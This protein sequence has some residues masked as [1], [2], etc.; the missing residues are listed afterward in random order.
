MNRY[1]LL[2]GI[3]LV[4]LTSPGTAEEEPFLTVDQ[5]VDHPAPWFESV[6]PKAMRDATTLRMAVVLIEFPDRK[7]DPRTTPD[8]VREMLFSRGEHVQGADGKAAHGSLADYYAVQSYGRLAVEGHVFDWM[9][10]ETPV[11]AL[12][13][14]PMVNTRGK[15]REV[16]LATLRKREGEDVLAGYH[17]IC[18]VGAGDPG[19]RGRGLWPHRGKIED[20]P[21]I[22]LSEVYPADQLLQ[23]GVPAHEFGH[24]FG[25]KDMYGI[26]NPFRGPGP[27]SLMAR[28]T[29][30]GE[31]SERTRPFSM[32]AWCRT[33]IG[34]LKPVTVDPRVARKVVL[35]PTLSGP[36]Q[37][38]RVLVKEDGSEYFL[39]EVRKREGWETDLPDEGL[40][41]WHVGERRN[42]EGFPVREY[43][44]ILEQPHPLD[45]NGA[46]TR[47]AAFSCWPKPGQRHF[48]P[49]SSPSSRSKSDDALPVF[50]RNITRREDGSV[51]LEIGPGP[52]PGLIPAT[53]IETRTRR[54]V[55]IL[56][57]EE[58]DTPPDGASPRDIRREIDKMLLSQGAYIGKRRSLHRE[59]VA[60]SLRDYVEEATCLRESL[61]GPGV[62]RSDGPWTIVP[63]GSL[64]DPAQAIRQALP[65]KEEPELVIA[66]AALPVRDERYERGTLTDGTPYL[67][68]RCGDGHF[69]HVG[70]MA[71][72]WMEVTR[73]PAR[74]GLDDD[75]LLGTGWR[76][77][78]DTGPR[79][80][81]HPCLHCKLRA[82]WLHLTTSDRLRP[83]EIYGEAAW[84]A[85]G[86]SMMV[87]R[88][89][90][91]FEADREADFDTPQIVDM[92]RDTAY[93]TLA[94]VRRSLL[95]VGH[96]TSTVGR[97]LHNRPIYL[98]R[99]A[100]PGSVHPDE[101]P[102]ILITAA[103][104]GNEASTVPAVMTFVEQVRPRS[105]RTI[106]VMP[107]V[108]A[109]AYEDFVSKPYTVWRPRANMRPVDDDKDG[110]L[111]EDGYEDLNGDGQIGFMRRL[112][113][114]KWKMLGREGIDNDED[115][116]FSED[117]PGGVDLNR[118][119]PQG[120]RPGRGMFGLSRGVAPLSEPESKA[121]ADVLRSHP[122]IGLVVDVHN[123]A[124]CLF[125]RLGNPADRKTDIASLP[126]YACYRP[127]MD[128]AED[129]F[130]YPTRRCGNAGLLA[131]WAYE[132][133]GI[134]GT[135][136]E[137]GNGAGK[138]A[139]AAGDAEVRN[140]W[141]R[142]HFDVDGWNDWKP[143]DH[144]QLGA[145]EIG[146]DWKTFVKRSP[147]AGHALGVVCARTRHFLDQCVD[148]LPR[149]RLDVETGTPP[150]LVITNEGALPTAS[151]R[152]HALE[153]SRARIV[154]SVE[155]GAAIAKLPEDAV[156]LQR[157]AFEVRVALPAL[158][159]GGAHRLT[160]DASREIVAR[161]LPGGPIG[162]ALLRWRPDPS[163]GGDVKIVQMDA[164][165]SHY[166]LHVPA[167]Y[168]KGAKV[169]LLVDLHGA[170]PV[171]RGPARISVRPWKSLCAE[172]GFIH[173]LP[174][175]RARAWGHTDG[176]EAFVN[177]CI[178]HVIESYDIDEK[179]IWLTGFSAGADYALHF[180]TQ[181]PKRFA[182][183][184][185]MMPGQFLY[186]RAGRGLSR[187]GLENLKEIPL[188]YVTGSRDVRRG[189]VRKIVF[190]LREIGLQSH[191]REVPDVGHEFPGQAEYARIYAFLSGTDESGDAIPEFELAKKAV[192]GGHVVIAPAKKAKGTV[193]V[194]PSKDPPETRPELRGV[195]AGCR[196]RDEE[197]LHGVAAVEREGLRRRVAE[198]VREGGQGA[199]AGDPV[200]ARRRGEPRRA[201]RRR[202]R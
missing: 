93:P 161:V 84:S 4:G 160:L 72:W 188:L 159:A 91:G 198:R 80:P 48:T 39:L 128:I 181:D 122:N 20:V 24:L 118:N 67:L 153:P 113:D 139:P 163:A 66:F 187:E 174:Q 55:P 114:G 57:L 115:G 6:T 35:R 60:G 145:I 135:I 17:A 97:T 61:S 104:H 64:A 34:W 120:W 44:T 137:I 75:C 40:L 37:A 129:V 86:A 148:A 3:L 142:R 23:V 168:K 95:E 156:V 164:H 94:D 201:P 27:W 90:V 36:R 7:H 29:H 133:N 144:P 85:D 52:T 170:A 172:H 19:R 126:D 10:I 151:H 158:P 154:L 149:L 152:L 110:K 191:I 45:V 74:H 109:D 63:A 185:P 54:L 162:G 147:P 13:Q 106:Y 5:L 78:G 116:K 102:A 11:A 123:D 21:Y 16:A 141:S 77:A 138:R 105:D 8:G 175:S 176:D 173:V 2:A 68:V 12:L 53:K 28:G 47:Y 140:A 143:F 92:T 46:T 193:V 165:S 169:P 1:A 127:V 62:K 195:R 130:G 32:C 178:E 15:Y 182:A 119:F 166:V 155:P 124:D 131:V 9:E 189:T 59:E 107:C 43:D 22:Q 194:L 125:I 38:L 177:A 41:I 202:R 58:D 76:G 65:E 199:Q 83:L 167:S 186:G 81:F 100:A 146:G 180:M 30:G 179:R 108:N 79:R 88:A 42:V 69:G 70:P 171:T 183:A 197:R 103:L 112:E 25:F 18:F 157:N 101:R 89:K 33:Q 192:K 31:P 134:P 196:R 71:R 51:E 111:D 82:G 98:V 200:L 96:S 49:D 50:L 121:V 26:R 184:A 190:T 87:K 73:G 150:T 132:A 56:L 136:L 99:I 117:V 14:M